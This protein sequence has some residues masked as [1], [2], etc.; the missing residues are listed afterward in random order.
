M[1][2]LS[3]DAPTYVAPTLDAETAGAIS[4]FSKKN[5]SQT[6]QDLSRQ[7]MEGTQQAAASFAPTQEQFSQ[8]EQALGGQDPRALYQALSNR[9]KTNTGRE[10]DKLKTMSDY[11]GRVK[12]FGNTQEEA[13]YSLTLDNFTRQNMARQRAADFEAEAARNSVLSSILGVT[14]VVVGTAYANSKNQAQSPQTYQ[15]PQQDYSGSQQLQQ[16]Q[17]GSSARKGP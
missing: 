8:S 12:Q 13:G 11:Q 14:G 1:G 2:I 17:L 5:R 16:P 10:I 4:D 3:G 9:Y 15:T 7:S 6:A